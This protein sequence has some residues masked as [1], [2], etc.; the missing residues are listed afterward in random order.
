M[1][2]KNARRRAFV[3]TTLNVIVSFRVERNDRNSE[4]NVIAVDFLNGNGTCIS[5]KR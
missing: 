1:E 2:W 4:F 5:R 3:F